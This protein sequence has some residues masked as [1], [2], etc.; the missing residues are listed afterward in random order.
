MRDYIIFFLYIKLFIR[1]MN[2]PFPSHY[3]AFSKT[4]VAFFIKI[5]SNNKYIQSETQSRQNVT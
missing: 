1:N 2:I 3:I 5:D 4:S